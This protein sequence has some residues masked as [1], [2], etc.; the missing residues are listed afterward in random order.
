MPKVINYEV[1]LENNKYRLVYYED[2][3]CEAFRYG[4]SWPALNEIMLG[5]K[6]I[7]ALV[8][9][10]SNTEKERE[11]K[12]HMGSGLLVTPDSEILAL[13]AKDGSLLNIIL[14]GI[15]PEGEEMTYT[16]VLLKEKWTNTNIIKE[17]PT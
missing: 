3:T 7:Q 12:G 14:K 6:V 10:I 13:M 4:E 17:W 1:S 5:S 8:A 2:G 11:F 16:V 15:S 9:R